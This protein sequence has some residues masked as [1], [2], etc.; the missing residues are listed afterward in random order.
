MKQNNYP[1]IS[2]IIP[3]KG[4]AEELRA[5]LTGLHHMDVQVPYETI[6]V[7]SNFDPTV[8]YTVQHFPNIK[9]IQSKEN[10]NAGPA[11]NLGVTQAA[12]DFLAFIDADC[13]PTNHWL[14]TAYDELARGAQMVGGPVL[15]ALPFH[16]IAT[17]DN[18][19]QFADL[20][21]KRPLGKA[22]VLPACNLAVR[23]EVF[24]TVSGFP[25]APTIEDSLFTN[26]IAKHW[27]DNCLF[28]PK[29]QVKHRGRTTLKELWYHQNYFGLMRGIFGFRVKKYQQILACRWYFVPLIILKR[30][31]Y[32][33]KRTYMWNPGLLIRNFLF[34]PLIVFGQLAWAVGF[35]QGCRR[36]LI[37]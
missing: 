5:C 35:R 28:I 18:L 12:G 36:R 22:E 9:V 33:F 6:V 24:E 1:S 30:L 4:H 26:A 14:Q 3:C 32:I 21:P 29:M 13:I 23:K 37:A 17:S 25:N 11:R 10:L 20:G 8:R 27:P 15:D 31:G 19:L 34:L 2:V 16:P 7:D